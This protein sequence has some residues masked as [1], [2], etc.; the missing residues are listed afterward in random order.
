M[1]R[2]GF[3]YALGAYFAWGLLP[4]YWKLLSKVD[5]IQLIGHRIVWSFCMLFFVIVFTKQLSKLK[6]AILDKKTVLIYVLAAVL[7][8]IN[9]YVYVWAVNSNYII[10]TSLGYFINPLISVAFGVLFFRERLKSFQ[11]VSLSFALIGVIYL[12]VVYGKL[13]WIALTLA[14]SFGFYGLVKKIAP[15][16]ALFGLT[17]ETGILFIP[18]LI[19]LI[20]FETSGH[21][22]FLHDSLQTNIL[23]IGAGLVTSAPLVFFAS[24]AQ[25]IPLAMVGIMQYIAPTLQ[26]LLGVFVFHESFN[27]TRL[28]GFIF[29][30]MGLLL[31]M[32]GSWIT[33][34]NKINT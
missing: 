7:I 33:R 21:G 8:A 30:W 5:A 20:F 29:V 26:F 25:E 18:A 6:T 1:L 11:W 27:I 17:V 34:K 23:L 16:G 3:W 19:M 24:A 32:L 28:I 14:I 12:T 22:Y 4:I 10:E 15:L 9:W 2:K 13:P 31:F